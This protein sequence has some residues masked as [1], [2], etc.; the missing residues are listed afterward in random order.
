MQTIQLFTN[1]IL[2]LFVSSQPQEDGLT[3]L[4]VAGPLGKLD[5]GDQYRLNPFAPLHD[6]GGYTQSPSPRP[7]FGQINKG[8]RRAPN[9]EMK[10]QMSRKSKIWLPYTVETKDGARG[11]GTYELRPDDPSYPKIKEWLE[12][13][14]RCECRDP[15]EIICQG[16]I[17]LRG[18]T[19]RV[20]FAKR[21]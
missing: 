17:E 3:K 19:L 12:A 18:P 16:I 2:C 15:H 7:F 13:V 4:I 6:R 9:R 20:M 14:E 5:L 21:S 10:S 8:T 11:C 1:D